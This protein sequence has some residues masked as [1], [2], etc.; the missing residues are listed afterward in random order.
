MTTLPA[1][2]RV[3]SVS[4]CG[5]VLRLRHAARQLEHDNYMRYR[6]DDLNGNRTRTVSFRIGTARSNS[7]RSSC[8][9]SAPCSKCSSF[10]SLDTRAEG[11]AAHWSAICQSF[12]QLAA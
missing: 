12:E 7:L 4:S 9:S 6:S 5:Q 8:T 3:L 2:M 10:L 11:D 1:R